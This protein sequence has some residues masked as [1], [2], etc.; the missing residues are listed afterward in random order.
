MN[1]IQKSNEYVLNTYKRYPLVF[2]YGKGM[3]L[4]T[5]KGK[6]FLDMA[7]GIAVS[8]LGHAH[9]EIIK[10]ISNQTK[11]LI[12]TSN[13][14]YSMPYTELAEKLIKKSVFSKVFFCNSGAEANEAALK[15][16][17]KYGNSIKNHK[18]VEIIAMKNSF[19][20]RTIATVSITGQTK[21]QKG[22]SPLLKNIKF[23][24]FNNINDLKKK[25]NN[26]TCA[27]ILEPIQGE[28]GINQ[29]DMSFIIA[30]RDL[31][32]KYNALL[33]FDEIQT[34]IGRTGKLFAYE[35]F[36]PV[37]PD[38]ITVA[39]GLAAGLP[40]GVMLVKEQYSNVFEP[41]NHASTFGG[42]L[43][44]C[45][46]ANVVID[47]ITKDKFLKNLNNTANY[48]K[49]KLIE[50]KNK[51]K[52]IVEVRGTGYLIGI[53]IDFEAPD[54]IN[55]LIEKNIIA[56]PAGNNVVRFIP[57]LIADKE[58]FEIV[59]KALDKIFKGKK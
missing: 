41:G 10:A 34:G 45:S 29:A 27:V 58:H 1:I 9:P 6:R 39:K 51:Y 14:Y 11:K 19:H 37:E 50:L 23:T 43:V 15:L 36:Q 31:C 16:A 28:G 13:L 57:P 12:H 52:Q 7:S 56:V 22:F 42:N 26:N 24:E 49:N 38:I 5:E 20:G 59:I 25:I 32:D 17:R 40:I 30:A 35:H 48:F 3:Y 44:S 33:I 21:Y 8:S 4:Y 55:K 18:K 46:S 2:D 47:T 53:E 54:L